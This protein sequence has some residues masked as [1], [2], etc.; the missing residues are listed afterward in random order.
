MATA[1][2]HFLH[3]SKS[4]SEKGQAQSTCTLNV[5]HPSSANPSGNRKSTLQSPQ[6]LARAVLR[7]TM[8]AASASSILLKTRCRVKIVTESTGRILE[9][10]PPQCCKTVTELPFS[11]VPRR[12]PSGGVAQVSPGAVQPWTHCLSS[13]CRKW[14]PWF[15]WNCV[16]P[17]DG[18][19][20]AP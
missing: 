7:V 17:S 18:G 6:L 16:E 3:V 4:L 11:A 10:G 2:L 5:V 15:P 13:R 14:T 12:A 8:E 9:D 1:E 19:L 20:D